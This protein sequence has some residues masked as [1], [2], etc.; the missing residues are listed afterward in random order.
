MSVTEAVSRFGLSRPTFYKVASDFDREGLPGL[1][2]RKRGPKA[3][4]KLTPEIVSYLEEI[5]ARGE[6][7]PK[8]LSERVS[9]QYGRTIHPRT[10]QRAL[11]QRKKNR[12]DSEWSADERR[13]RGAVRGAAA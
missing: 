9:R 3:P 2:P 6:V 13:P 5:V 1:L 7:D 8:A 4:H 11:A 10:I 12:T